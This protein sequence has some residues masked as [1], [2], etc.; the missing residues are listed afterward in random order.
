MLKPTILVIDADASARR[1]LVRNLTTQF[2]VECVAD[3][4]AAFAAIDAGAHYDAV[5]CEL[6]SSGMSSLNLRRELARRSGALATRLVI[7]GGY[8]SSTDEA[9]APLHVTPMRPRSLSIDEIR[10]ALWVAI[11]PRVSLPPPA[12]AALAA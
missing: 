8:P 5:L 10:E 2:V 1:L 11:G 6:P 4:A 3:A 7:T 9:P 12:S